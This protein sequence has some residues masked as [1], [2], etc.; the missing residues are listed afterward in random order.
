MTDDFEHWR[1][2]LRDIYGG[3]R[4][5]LVGEVLVLLAGRAR[6]LLDLGAEAVFMVGACRGT[7]EVPADLGEAVDLGFEHTAER[8]IMAGIR[9]ASAALAT[10]PPAVRERVEAFDPAGEARVIGVLHDDGR[11]LAGR[12]RW[13]AS[14]PAWQALEDKIRILDLFRE[15][16]ARL[17]P[18]RVVPGE[19]DALLAAHRE[20]AGEA[21]TVWAADDTEGWHGGAEGTWWVPDE[22]AARRRAE[23]VAGR[24]R[25]LRVTPFLEGVPCSVHGF[26]L[27]GG[28]TVV[29]R[30]A[31]LYVLR[32]ADRSGFEYAG[33]GTTWDPPPAGRRELRDLARRLGR[34]L[35][36]RLGFRGAFVLDG[37]MTG[38]GFRP[39]ELNPRLGAS[40]AAMDVPIPLDLLHNALAEGIGADWRPRALEA[41][42][43]ARLDR[44]RGAVVR[45]TP[46]EAGE[47]RAALRVEGLAV[48]RARTDAETHATAIYGPAPAS[49]FV[50]VRFREGALPV[51]P[52]AAPVAA[53]VLRWLD[54]E[55]NLRLAGMPLTPAVEQA[56]SA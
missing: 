36:A 56:R 41:A 18:L 49:G 7:G 29:L 50:S 27:P 10:L 46:R 28:E 13:G 21:G 52:S 8:G 51:G 17:P 25:T 33:A 3:R 39:T 5:L 12:R 34:L 45:A 48:R 43:L 15:V 38:E 4:W 22:A 11:D 16:G 44:Q 24:F 1:G 9:A 53:A 40:L 2:I 37:V 47:A 30:P 42:L 14:R 26:V 19:T 23:A 54:A 31:E 20:L 6:S 55:W 32:R 35:H